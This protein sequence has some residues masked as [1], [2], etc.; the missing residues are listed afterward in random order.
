MYTKS[1]PQLLFAKKKRGF[2][3]KDTMGMSLTIPAIAALAMLG[4]FV[5]LSLLQTAHEVSFCV[6]P[7]Q[8]FE[9]LQI[10]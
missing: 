1:S 9:T 3:L 10:C 5:S 6:F 2:S 4:I 7:P 8:P